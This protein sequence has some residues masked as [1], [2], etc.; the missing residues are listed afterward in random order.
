MIGVSNVNRTVP[1]FNAGGVPD[2]NIVAAA[3]STFTTKSPAVGF[4]GAVIENVNVITTT[5]GITET[6]CTSNCGR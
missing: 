1:P 6:T 5:D 2:V 3:L 4:I